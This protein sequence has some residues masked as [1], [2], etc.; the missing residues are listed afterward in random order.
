MLRLLLKAYCLAVTKTNSSFFRKGPKM[1]LSTSS[2]AEPPYKGGT[3]RL[4]WYLV[5]SGGRKE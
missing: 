1:R 4:F 2:R 3:T 5:V